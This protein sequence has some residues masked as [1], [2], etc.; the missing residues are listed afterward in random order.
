MKKF[1]FVVAFI[2]LAA[3]SQAA[4]SS[5]NKDLE[6][7]G[8]NRDLVRRAGKVSSD[9]VIRIVQKREVERETRLEFVAN[10]MT[11]AGGDPYLD[12]STLGLGLEFHIN[13]KFSLGVQHARYSNAF[14]AEGRRVSEQLVQSQRRLDV[15]DFMTSSTLLSATWYPVYGKINW[16]D[17]GVT[18]FDL[19]TSVLGGVTSLN[20]SGDAGTFGIAGGFA[21]WISQHVAARI[22]VRYQTHSDQVFSESEGGFQNRRLDLTAIGASIGFLL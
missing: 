12:S 19:Y 4:Q 22:E 20:R 11:W 14:S 5:L 2:T 18:Q 17:L 16:F 9:S 21:L 3:T 15:Y 8:A 1:A 10:Q 6:T 7:L 13:P